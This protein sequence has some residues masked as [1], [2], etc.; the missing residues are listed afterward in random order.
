MNFVMC[1]YKQFYSTETAIVQVHTDIKLNFY[2][3]IGKFTAA[4]ATIDHDI[5]I[6]RLS[7]C[8]T[9]MAQH[10]ASF[11]HTWLIDD[12]KPLI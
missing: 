1:T 2:N 3:S 4:F 8:A 10:W 9:Y 12:S 5:P 11:L 7:S 6:R